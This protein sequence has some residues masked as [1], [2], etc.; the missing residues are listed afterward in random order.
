[1]AL[2]GKPGGEMAADEAPGSCDPDLCHGYGRVH[3][4]E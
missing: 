2:A 4:N 1:V 3:T